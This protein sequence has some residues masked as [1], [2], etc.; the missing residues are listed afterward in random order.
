MLDVSVKFAFSWPADGVAKGSLL[1]QA[2]ESKIDIFGLK[3]P[4][5]EPRTKFFGMPKVFPNAPPP[6]VDPRLNPGDGL[7][8]EPRWFLDGTFDENEISTNMMANM[9]SSTPILIA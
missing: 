2:L 7:R 1:H 6:I 4:M 8:T 3:L 5:I 9:F